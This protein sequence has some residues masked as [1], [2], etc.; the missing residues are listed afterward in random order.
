[1][2]EKAVPARAG[3]YWR[4]G[5]QVTPGVMA[6][7]SGILSFRTDHDE[8]F[9]ASVAQVRA[10]FTT[11]ST[12][13]VR[14]GEERFAFVTGAYAGAL[15]PS[16]SDEQLALLAG[17]GAQDSTREFSRGAATL[18]TSSVIGSAAT[19]AGSVL[20][21]V[22]GVAGQAVAVA[23]IAGAQHQAFALARAWAEYLRDHG[24]AVALRG[25]TFARSQVVVAAIV[26]PGLV[27]FGVAVYGILS[28]LA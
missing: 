18:V 22:V 25:T 15:A 3:L 24:V 27:V 21:R 14:V 17:D 10:T 4:R 16:F 1:M 2:T 28:M 11:F 9:R 7:E 19:L 26:I 20:G 12:L 8:V 6:L 23:R 5:A 13:V